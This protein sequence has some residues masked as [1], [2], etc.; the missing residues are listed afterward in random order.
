MTMF[1]SLIAA[2][3]LSLLALAP[4]VQAQGPGRD[5]PQFTLTD[6]SGKRVDLAALRGKTVVL[7]WTNPAC[8]FVKKHYGS[9]NMQALQKRFTGQ[10][11]VWVTINSTATGHPEYLKPAQQSDWMA[12]QGGSPTYVALDADGKVGRA[13]GARTTPHMYVI[14]PAGKLAYAGAIDDKRSTNPAD[15]KTANNYVAQAIGELKAGKPVS[16]PA[17]PAYGCSIKYSDS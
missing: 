6:V 4:G 8:P 10:E 5:A 1:K 12:K 15:V 17:T 3:S 13:Y 7:E 2:A 9:G 11:V 16:T 14:D